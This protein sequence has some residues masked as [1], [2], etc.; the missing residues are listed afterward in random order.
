MSTYT[1][2]IRYTK[3]KG[4]EETFSSP[5]KPTLSDDNRIIFIRRFIP[6]DNL[7]HGNFIPTEHVL[8]MTVDELPDIIKKVSKPDAEA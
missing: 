4:G 5:E 6:S 1:I 3:D 8:N 7:N 2:K